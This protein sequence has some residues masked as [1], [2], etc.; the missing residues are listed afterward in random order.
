MLPQGAKGII[1]DRLKNITNN[2]LFADSSQRAP[3]SPNC[4]RNKK[5]IM[6][7]MNRYLSI[8]REFESPAAHRELNEVIDDR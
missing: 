5:E 3:L 6:F 8:G 7:Y 1:L 2:L 4:S